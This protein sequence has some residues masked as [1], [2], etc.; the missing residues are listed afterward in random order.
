MLESFAA[1]QIGPDHAVNEDSYVADDDLRLYI[2]ADGMG[3]QSAGEVASRMT[4]EL[5]SNFIRQSEDSDEITWPF[6]IDPALSLNGN[7]LQ[8][9]VQLANRKVWKQADE[10]EEYLGMG[11]TVVAALFGQDR[12]TISAAGDSRV[13]RI[14]DG[15]IQQLTEDDSWIRVALSEGLTTD[16]KA[17]EHPMRN[18]VTKAIGAEESIEPELVEQPVEDGDLYVLCSDGLYKHLDDASLLECVAES[19]GLEQAAQRMMEIAADNGA[20]DDVTVL[21]VRHTSP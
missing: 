8:T 19:D 1:S 14:R 17:R 3:G 7:R 20:D 10:Q 11:T 6:G 13:Y 2:L 18:L 12:A 4:V 9:A 16:E 21:L 5:I 15:E